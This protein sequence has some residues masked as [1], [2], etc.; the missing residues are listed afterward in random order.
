MT[1]ASELSHEHW[2]ELIEKLNYNQLN[3]VRVRIAERMKHMRENGVEQM[4]LKF[5]ED[6]AALGLAPEDIFAPPKK[7]RRKRRR[8]KEEDVTKDSVP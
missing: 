4:R 2:N 1:D 3:D 7:Q 8:H 6:G 5:I